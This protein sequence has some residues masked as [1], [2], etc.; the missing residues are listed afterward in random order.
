MWL[1]IDT[2]LAA[3]SVA[4]IDRGAVVAEAHEAIARGHAERLV[5]MVGEV[6][7]A[8]PGARVERVVVDVGPG[9]FTG[10][11]V[12]IAAARAFGLA[13]RCQVAG[14]TSTAL[15]AA[16]V[17]ADDPT[18]GR[19]YIVL[20]AARGEIYVQGFLREGA[21]MQ[22]IGPVE[23]LVPEAAAAR[24]GDQPVAG[25]GAALIGRSLALPSLPRAADARLLSE[26]SF[27]L[28]T[29]LYVRPPDAKPSPGRVAWGP[30]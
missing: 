5:P 8:A 3:C 29:P 26:H 18:L 28:P 1:A 6:L 9:S 25:S 12:G 27:G 19:L 16:R 15:I 21:I 14:M 11:R 30:A 20:D 17:A 22:P 2:A 13:W 7:T 23:A 24:I 4:L 10:L